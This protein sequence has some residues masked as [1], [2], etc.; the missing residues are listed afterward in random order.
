MGFRSDRAPFAR[1]KIVGSPD[2]RTPPADLLEKPRVTAVSG[3]GLPRADRDAHLPSLLPHATTTREP[4][5]HSSPCSALP[6]GIGRIKVTVVGLA[7][8][9][10]TN[11]FSASTAGPTA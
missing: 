11:L 1:P 9:C 5:D 10:P 4:S 3:G 6:T 2:P 8:R 7:T